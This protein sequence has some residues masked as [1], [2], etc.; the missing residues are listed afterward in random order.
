MKNIKIISLILCLCMT[1]FMAVSC[2]TC[3]HE[4]EKATLK[5]AKVL[6]NGIAKYTCKFCNDSYE[7]EIPAT[8]KIK[9]LAIGNSFSVDSME[10]LWNMCNDAGAEEVVLGNLYVGGC[11]LDTHYQNITNNKTAYTYYKNTSGKWETTKNVALSTALQEESW[12]IIT[13]QQVSGDSGRA[14][15]YAVLSEIV[16]Y[17]KENKTNPD[18]EILWNMTWAYAQ[19]STHGHFP[20]YNSDQNTMYSA[21]TDAVQ[22]AVLTNTDIE[23]VIPT[24]TAVQNLRSSYVGDTLNR[25]NSHLSYSQG[26]YVAAM[27]WYAYLTGGKVE[28]VDWVPDEYG[29]IADDLDA[30]Y[31]AVNNAIKSPFEATASKFTDK[32]EI[33]DEERF[34]ALGLDISDYEVLDWEPKVNALYNSTITMKLRDSENAKDGMLPYTIASK[35]FT[36]ETLPIGSV[37]IVDYEYQ[38]RPEGWIEENKK[39]SSSTRPAQ[40]TYPIT[41]IGEDWWENYAF[42]AINLMHTGVRITLTEEDVN[43]LRIYV[44][45][46]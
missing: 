7:E 11:S 33:T 20:R 27:T 21:I 2:A 36:K 26:R 15:T 6:E 13:I 31:E 39:N 5:E 18:A 29:Y 23:G 38:Y 40:V 34:K 30:I 10:Y 35:M 9:V 45:K 37:I 41:V 19:N 1:A 12:D 24:G 8:R 25:D 46:A 22:S 3:E 43:H 17:V 32:K 14:D 4:Y 28:A 44:P 42:R 16:N